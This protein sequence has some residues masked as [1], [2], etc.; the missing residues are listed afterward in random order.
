MFGENSGQLWVMILAAVA[1]GATMVAVLFPYIGGRASGAK[2]L[3]ALSEKSK[4]PKMS[5]EQ[6]LLQEDTQR[7]PPQ[8]GAGE[9]QADRSRRRRTAS[10]R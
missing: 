2:R 1:V 4:A 10:A 3:E 7:F 9:P 8:A 5:L 6:R